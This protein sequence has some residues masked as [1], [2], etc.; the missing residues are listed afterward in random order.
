VSAVWRGRWKPLERGAAG[1]PDCSPARDWGLTRGV[2]RRKDGESPSTV[3][4]PVFLQKSAV[5]PPPATLSWKCS[6]R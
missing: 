2:K 4:D 1:G 6:G 3:S 5:Q